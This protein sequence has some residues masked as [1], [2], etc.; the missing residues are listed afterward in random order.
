M[1]GKVNGYDGFFDG[2]V[3]KKRGGKAIEHMNEEF[4]AARLTAEIDIIWA[5]YDKE[6]GV[7][8]RKIKNQRLTDRIFVV[9][10]TI[11]PPEIDGV[12]LPP[13][14]VV[15]PSIVLEE[16]KRYLQRLPPTVKQRVNLAITDQWSFTLS[17]VPREEWVLKNLSFTVTAGVRHLLE[18]FGL[19]P[20][21]SAIEHINPV[22]KAAMGE[23]VKEFKGAVK[24]GLSTRIA[25]EDFQFDL[26]L[27]LGAT[28]L[29]T[30]FSLTPPVVQSG[31]ET[32]DAH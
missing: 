16:F 11:Q 25:N 31:K 7:I 24:W 28:T 19:I 20:S 22:L 29:K 12:Q 21:Q 1:T 13:A 27:V 26:E 10:S 23:W 4:L 18:P 14:P 9:G 30:S 8:G 2:P 3:V 5:R 17:I 6:A 15:V 32:D